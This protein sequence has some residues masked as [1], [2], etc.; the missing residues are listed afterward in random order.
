MESS[1]T[2]SDPDCSR[3]REL[4]SRLL[5]LETRLRDLEDRLKGPPPKRAHEPI[6]L[7]A[8]RSPSGKKPGGQ[9]GHP[10]HIRKWL[11]K[12]H[13][14]ETV[15]FVPTHCSSCDHV[16]P[17]EA[18]P[19][20]PPPTIHQ[21]YELPKRLIDVTQFEG[22]TRTCPD[23]Q[24]VTHHAIPASVRTGIL[25]PKLAAMILYPLGV[26][27]LSKRDIEATLE[28]VFELPISL[29]TIAN[30][31][32]KAATALE[33]TYQAIRR[34]VTDA[35][36]KGFDETG[37]NENGKKRCLWVAATVKAALFRIHPRRNETALADLI[38]SKSGIAVSDR[39]TTYNQ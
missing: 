35:P 10:P 13:V 34:V 24:T 33:P 16:L 3:C 8:K 9:R 14:T 21:T 7:P 6:P 38:P 2:Q 19:H 26:L 17:V 15:P 5:V 28:T 23:C 11:V 31:E 30:L 12:E 1:A 22:H 39:W 4:E 20:D 25:G 37:W 18:Q 29:G 27:G 36:V 32:Q